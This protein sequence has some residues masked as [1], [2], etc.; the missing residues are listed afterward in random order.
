MSSVF[1][2][3]FS[4]DVSIHPR[5]SVF[6]LGHFG[7]YSLVYN[8]FYWKAGKKYMTDVICDKD[9]TNKLWSYIKSKGQEFIEVAPLK[10]QQGFL[11]S[12]NRYS[13]VYNKFYFYFK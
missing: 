13:L 4:S 5:M 12:D 8:K 3:D 10:N 9:N 7:W 2:V 6:W 1:L 11:K